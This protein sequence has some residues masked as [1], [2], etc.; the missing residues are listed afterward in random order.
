V[1]LIVAN[2]VSRTD[3][4]FEVETN[5]A[6]LVDATGT[7]ELPLQSKQDLARQIVDRVEVFLRRPASAIATDTDDAA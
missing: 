1:D 6:T 4:G 3:A 7:T 2:D 5:A